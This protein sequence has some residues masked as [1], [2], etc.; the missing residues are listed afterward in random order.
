[1]QHL[2]YCRSMVKQ[3][4]ATIQVPS[5]PDHV[6]R[7]MSHLIDLSAASQKFILPDGG[8]VLDDAELRGLDGVLRLPY[9][10]LALEYPVSEPP[11]AGLSRSSK[12]ILFARERDDGLIACS[13]VCWADH[14]GAWVAFADF[15]LSSTDYLV[16][17]IDGRVR[18][19]IRC[20]P[21]VLADVQQEADSLFSFLNAVA[22]SNVRVERSVSKVRKAMSMR[23]GALP[24][25]DYHILTIDARRRDEAT[26]DLISLSHR[27]PREH[28][29]RGHIRR[30]ESGLKVWVNATVVNPGVGGKI[31]KDYRLIA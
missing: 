5:L 10:F 21:A 8:R 29:R 4:T 25:D 13:I 15:A 14:H 23:K 28:L 26:G 24:F 17:R 31:A 2:N 9:P 12:R 1:M 16:E 18:L 7:T 11:E 30:Y 6:R 19:N 3:F 22:C 20:H 27:S